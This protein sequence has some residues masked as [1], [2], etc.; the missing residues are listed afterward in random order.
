MIEMFD[1]VF[2]NLD[3]GLIGI[4]V[5]FENQVACSWLIISHSLNGFTAPDHDGVSQGSAVAV[6]FA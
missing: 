5:Q 2:E 1:S 3:I 6:G 4:R